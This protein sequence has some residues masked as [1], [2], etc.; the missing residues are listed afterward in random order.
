MVRLSLS[1]VLVITAALLPVWAQS[2]GRKDLPVE[3]D[4]IQSVPPCRIFSGAASD[5]M[6]VVSSSYMPGPA[7]VDLPLDQLKMMVPFLDVAVAAGTR[8]LDKGGAATQ[9]LDN[10]ESILNKSGAAIDE[11]LRRTPN[12]IADEKVQLLGQDQNRYV[13]SS[14]RDYEYRIV[15]KPIPSGGNKLVESRTDAGG[16]PVDNSAKNPN[17]PINVGFAT[18]WLIFLPGNLHDS[19]FRYLGEQSMGRRKTY[20][21][22]FAQ[23]PESTGLQ[24]VISY[25]SGQCTAPLQ[26]VVWIDQSTFQ[27]VRMQTDLLYSLPDIQL[28]QLRSVLTYELVK[29]AGLRL[30]LWLPRNVE[31]SWQTAYR[32]VQES[33]TYS[34]YRLFKATMKVLPGLR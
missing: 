3:R 21:L 18:L 16:Q 32:D 5:A 9:S 24:P 13:E 30:S 19:R 28:S 8:D 15:H 10:A 1:A 12:L 22:A 26:G 6:V 33:H 2:S 29:I 11:Q 34:H 4:S 7:Y 20:V 31:A 17:R 27:I 25:G 14:A 23:N